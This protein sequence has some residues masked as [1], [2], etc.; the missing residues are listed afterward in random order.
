MEALLELPPL[1]VMIEV[2]ALAGIYRL[3]CSR[4]WRPKSTNFGHAK[5]L[6]AWSMNLSYR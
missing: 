3:M 1:H 5:N 6:G 4:Q 2:E